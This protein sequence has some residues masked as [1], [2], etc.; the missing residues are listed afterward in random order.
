VNEPS[1]NPKPSNEEI[2]FLLSHAKEILNPYPKKEDIQSAFAGIRPLVKSNQTK[3]SSKLSRNHE[4]IISKSGLV[5]IVGGKWTTGR[6]MA[7]ETINKAFKKPLPCKTKNLPLHKTDETS[8]LNKIVHRALNEEM[9]LTPSDI[10]ARRTRILFLET[11]KALS[12]APEV[13]RL[14]SIYF[15]KD[16]TWEDDELNKFKEYAKSYWT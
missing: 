13:I 3:S 12:L 2:E 16:S 11:K 7:E 8:D 14:M 6:K 1:N 4:I 15:K 10:L 9:A 5:T